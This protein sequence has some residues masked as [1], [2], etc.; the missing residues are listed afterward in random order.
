MTSL[1]QA[2]VPTFAGHQTFHPRFGWLKK[3][4]D[5]ASED[6]TVF[7]AEDATVRLGVGKNMVE[8]IRFW[9][10]ATRIL[11]RVPDP[12]R[13][14]TSLAVPTRLGQALLAEDGF[15]PYFEDPTTLWVLH[16]QTCSPP[17]ALPVWWLTFSQMSALEFDED[18]LASFCVDEVSATTWGMPQE[19]SIRK[20]VDCLLRMY[21]TRSTRGR[22]TL[23]DLLDSPFRELGIIRRDS[24]QLDRYRFV[25]GSQPGLTETAVV[26]ACLDFLV[27]TD[28][29]ARTSFSREANHGPRFAGA[30]HE[31]DGAEHH[32][33]SRYRG[34]ASG[35]DPA[36]SSQAAPPR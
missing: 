10:L 18:D 2:A 27:R 22:Q 7:L 6:P 26:Y 35:R 3:G 20:D 5:R 30:D 4:F 21:T 28:P 36:G 23:D 19:S 24:V 34:E 11:C 1:E 29:N 13:P 31:A 16:W 33:R 15:D 17:Y 8:A 9:S 14:R 32:K 12:V 25:R